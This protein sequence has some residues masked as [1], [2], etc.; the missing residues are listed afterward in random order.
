MEK[1][2]SKERILRTVAGQPVDRVPIFAPVPWHPLAPEPDPKNWKAWPNYQR[3]LPLVAEHCDF[4]VHLDVAERVPIGNPGGGEVR[5]HPSGSIFDRRFFLAH[6]ENIR[7]IEDRLENGR[8]ITRYKVHT[9]K[10]DLTTTDV[11]FLDVDTVWTT[12]PL[13]KDVRD[14][15]KILSVSS[16]F[17]PPDLTAYVAERDRLGDRGAPVCF[18]SSPLV[19]ISRM[20]EFQQLL[21]WTITE[22]PLL[23]TMLRIIQERLSER[24][25]WALEHGVGPFFRFG[26]SEQSTPPMMSKRFFEQFVI[27]YEAPLW[28][29]VREAGGIVWVH[30]H[31]KVATVLNRF[32]ENGVQMLDPV[33]PPPQGDITIKEAKARAAA[34]PLTLVGNVE[35][36]D[37]QNGTPELIERLVREAICEGGRKHLIMG[38]SEVTVSA[39]NDQLRDNIIAYLETA[40]RYAPFEPDRN[41]TQ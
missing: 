29:M 7:V 2:A 33:E 14:A 8:A 13:I 36:S 41:G 12:E 30:C 4:F 38:T 9:P 3:L 5:G 11:R 37:L 32:M 35:M 27:G 28:K 25:H 40:A 6:P 31:G 21:E 22:R 10:G 15:D 23:D 39:V 1:L 26:G 17:D 16:R 19:M 24:L 18:F 20:M 34:G